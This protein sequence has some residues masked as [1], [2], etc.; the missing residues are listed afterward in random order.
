MHLRLVSAMSKHCR[1]TALQGQALGR[2]DP[3]AWEIGARLVWSPNSFEACP[4]PVNPVDVSRWWTFARRNRNLKAGQ[5]HSWDQRR[6]P[7]VSPL[8]VVSMLQKF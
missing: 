6:N 8:V 7:H 4:R 5:H 2:R 3:G 1:S